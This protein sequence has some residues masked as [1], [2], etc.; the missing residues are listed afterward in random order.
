MKTLVLTILILLTSLAY[1]ITGKEVYQKC[2]ALDIQFPE[3]VTAQACFETGWFKSYSARERN[4]LFGFR[5]RTYVTEENPNGYLSFDSWEECVI[6]YKGWQDRK[7]KGGDYYDF[8]HNVG[9]YE[10]DEI[11]YTSSLKRIINKHL[12]SWLL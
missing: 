10:A 5:H 7:Y 9:Y 11:H 1:S 2:T 4:N 3:I 6:Y 12:K 8:L